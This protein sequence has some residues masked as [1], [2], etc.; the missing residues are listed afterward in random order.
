M[1]VNFIIFLNSQNQ[2]V[3]QKGYDLVRHRR[4]NLNRHFFKDFLPIIN[5]SQ[6]E[7]KTQFVLTDLGLS[8]SSVQPIYKSGGQGQKGGT[9]IMGKLMN[10]SFIQSKGN[11]LSLTLALKKINNKGISSFM[12]VHNVNDFEIEGSYYIQDYA[13]KNTYKISFI[14]NRNFF[15]QKQEGMRNSIKYVITATIF[16]IFLILILLNRFVLSRVNQL[17]LQLNEIQS[18]KILNRESKLKRKVK[19]K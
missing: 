11:A 2:L 3:Y 15:L 19:M 7:T 13:Q 4:I 17:S 9:L 12:R 1:Q 8:M 18:K 5:S 6:L 10:K 16:F 14:S